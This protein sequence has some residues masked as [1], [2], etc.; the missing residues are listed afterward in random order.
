MSGLIFLESMRGMWSG[1]SKTVI[2]KR[3]GRLNLSSSH[4]QLIETNLTKLEKP[5]KSDETQQPLM[6]IFGAKR[7]ILINLYLAEQA[8]KDQLRSTTK[9]GNIWLAFR[10][11]TTVLFFSLLITASQGSDQKNSIATT[12]AIFGVWLIFELTIIRGTLS[13]FKS[14]GLIHRLGIPIKQICLGNALT[15]WIEIICLYGILIIL[16][17]LQ[18]FNVSI[19]EVLMI[20]PSLLLLIGLGLPYTALICSYSINRSDARF[21]LPIA[22]RFILLTIPIFENFHERFSIIAFAVK[23]SPL[24]LPF[25]L[26]S[27]TPK[28]A[29][30]EIISYVIF[31]LCGY[32]LSALFEKK[33]QKN[34]WIITNNRNSPK[35]I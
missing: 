23:F 8:F 5:S 7:V 14:K 17:S 35:A 30:N 21:L 28:V 10:Y 33:P 16:A 22:F 11:V 32:I 2:K 31:T 12:I 13:G 1:A 26:I 15:T 18:I 25:N 9:F 34:V 4:I 29:K 3:I 27:T 19:K 20:L 6:K 24:N